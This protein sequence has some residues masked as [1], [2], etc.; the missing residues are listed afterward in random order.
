LTFN[1]DKKYIITYNQEES[2]K[3][4]IKAVSFW[5]FFYEI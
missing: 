4:N 2:I 5:K 1:V 3:D